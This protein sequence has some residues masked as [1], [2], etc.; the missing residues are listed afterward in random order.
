MPDASGGPGERVYRLT[1][2]FDVGPGDD[3][4][5]RQLEEVPAPPG[6]AALIDP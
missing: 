6:A 5:L 4:L 1:E 3:L 2:A